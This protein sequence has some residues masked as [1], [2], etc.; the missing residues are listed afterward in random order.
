MSPEIAAQGAAFFQAVGLGLCAGLVYDLFR[1]LRVRVKL[2]LLGPL[3]DLLFWVLL[4]AALFIWSQG[5]WGGEVRWYGAAFLFGGGV[6]YFWL[7]SPWL[8]KLGYFLADI[9][10]FLWR[11]FTYPLVLLGRFAKKIKIFLKNTFHSWAKWY[12]INQI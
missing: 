4:T 5:A 2:P 10:A 12:R 3:L 7:A 1:I 9:A 11:I 6:L 8:L